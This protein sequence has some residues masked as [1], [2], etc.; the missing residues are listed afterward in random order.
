VVAWWPKGYVDI[1]DGKIAPVPAYSLDY[2]HVNWLQSSI[3]TPRMLLVL[4]LPALAGIIEIAGW[5]ARSLLV[6]PVV[7]TAAAYSAYYVTYQH[8]RF[9]FVALPPLFVLDAAGLTLV[10]RGIAARVARDD[11]G[12]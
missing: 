7:V 10:V 9:L 4:L 8:P 1:Y 6:M 2:V 5:Y 11:A 12:G 3:F